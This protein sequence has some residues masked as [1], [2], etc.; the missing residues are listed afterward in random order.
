MPPKCIYA[1]MTCLP[2]IT[3]HWGTQMANITTQLSRVSAAE[4][5]QVGK[6]DKECCQYRLGCSEVVS[7]G[8][9]DSHKDW[10]TWGSEPAIYGN[11]GQRGKKCHALFLWGQSK[12]EEHVPTAH[13]WDQKGA[14]LTQAWRHWPSQHQLV[15]SEFHLS[16]KRTRASWI[17]TDS[18]SATRNGQF[19]PARKQ[20]SICSQMTGLCPKALS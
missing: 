7:L 13:R 9:W 14:S 1:G 18:R 15:V 2:G 4:K 6:V 12:Q 17:I 10:R 3:F 20:G 19:C 16:L 5:T 11:R 8:R